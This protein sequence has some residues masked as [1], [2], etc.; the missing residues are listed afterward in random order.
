MVYNISA[1]D[2]KSIYYSYED[3]MDFYKKNKEKLSKVYST[4][5]SSPITVLSNMSG[6]V[7]G[8]TQKGLIIQGWAG[9][10]SAIP[11]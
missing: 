10:F 4:Y 6:W 7:T 2:G 5:I 1:T 8:I 9:E 3:L 11:N